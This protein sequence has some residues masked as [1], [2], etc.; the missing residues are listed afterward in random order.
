MEFGVLDLLEIEFLCLLRVLIGEAF[1]TELGVLGEVLLLVEQLPG[2]ETGGVMDV[3][4][5]VASGEAGE[6]TLEVEV[7]KMGEVVLGV[8]VDIKEESLE[9]EE[10]GDVRGFA[11]GKVGGVRE[12]REG[13]RGGSGEVREGSVVE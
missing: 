11:R 3:A 10:M 8:F 4:L 9:V 12:S 2:V 5:G 1:D 13:V 6:V 7:D